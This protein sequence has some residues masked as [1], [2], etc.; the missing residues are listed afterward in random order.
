MC[1]H[2][3]FTLYWLALNDLLA[4]PADSSTVSEGIGRASQQVNETP[5]EAGGSCALFIHFEHSWQPARPLMQRKGERNRKRSCYISL[6]HKAVLL[7]W[8]YCQW[9]RSWDSPG[10]RGKQWRDRRKMN[11]EKGFALK[12]H[13]MGKIF[14]SGPACIAFHTLHTLLLM[15]SILTC[16]KVAWQFISA[17][18]LPTGQRQIT[19]QLCQALASPPRSLSSGLQELTLHPSV[20][21]ALW[22][23]HALGLPAVLSK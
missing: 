10:S 18:V 19:P 17:D 3:R 5:S 1:S 16:V 13:I 11:G 15:K 21:S 9:V 20:L 4:L 22:Y 8:M 12:P 7:S 23:V 14:V 6:F 2:N